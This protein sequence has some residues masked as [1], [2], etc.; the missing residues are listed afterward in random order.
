VDSPENVAAGRRVVITAALMLTAALLLP[1]QTAAKA[2]G[3]MFAMMI[4]QASLAAIFLPLPCLRCSGIEKRSLSISC[5]FV[6]Y[7]L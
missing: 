6:S 1:A 3:A 5:K 4:I 7:G 2:D